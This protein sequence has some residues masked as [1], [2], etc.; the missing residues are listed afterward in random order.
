MKIAEIEIAGTRKRVMR[1]PRPK[2][3][4]QQAF[5]EKDVIDRL[6]E[7]PKDPFSTD[8]FPGSGGTYDIKSLQSNV[9]RQLMELAKSI[10]TADINDP[11]DPFMV[12]RAYK[13]LYNND[14]PVFQDKMETLVNAYNKL[15]K[16]NRYKKQFGEI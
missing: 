8:V 15:A 10:A 13:L 2:R 6:K 16:Q 7:D 14:N 11:A 12:R 9:A 3:R 5:T 1:G 4:I